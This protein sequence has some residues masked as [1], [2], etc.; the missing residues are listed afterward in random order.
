M[1]ESFAF[2]APGVEIVGGTEEDVAARI[3]DFGWSLGSWLNLDK[4][5]DELDRELLELV[6]IDF[7]SFKCRLAL[8]GMLHL[9]AE[10]SRLL[11]EERA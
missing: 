3:P 11:R 2:I 1:S 4:V 10:G 9:I 5:R 7:L 8:V 6:K